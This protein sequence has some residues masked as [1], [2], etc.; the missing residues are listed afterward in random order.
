MSFFDI[1]QECYKNTPGY[2]D[3]LE[4]DYKWNWNFFFNLLGF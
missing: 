3:P 1:F 2:N 4:D